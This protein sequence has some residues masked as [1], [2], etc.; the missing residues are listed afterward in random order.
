MDYQ[1]DQIYELSLLSLMLGINL[2]LLF[3]MFILHEHSLFIAL[4]K[5][6]LKSEFQ[7]HVLDNVRNKLL[8]T[9]FTV[10]SNVLTVTDENHKQCIFPILPVNV[11]KS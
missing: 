8:S 10:M 5:S 6:T 11:L 7:S 9:H 2:N 1:F 4:M 3:I